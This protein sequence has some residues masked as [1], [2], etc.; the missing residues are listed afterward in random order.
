MKIHDGD[1]DL[2]ERKTLKVSVPAKLHLQLHTVKILQGKNISDT[3]EAALEDYFED[4]IDDEP[5]NPDGANG[6]GASA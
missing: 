1:A 2:S 3:V 5:T 6:A 4:R